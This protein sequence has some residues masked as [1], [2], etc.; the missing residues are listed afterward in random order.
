M[1]HLKRSLMAGIFVLCA[2]YCLAA[3]KG[4]GCDDNHPTLE[5]KDVSCTGLR[6][7]NSSKFYEKPSAYVT[8]LVGWMQARTEV[9]RYMSDPSF[10]HFRH[11]FKLHTHSIAEEKIKIWFHV[12]DRGIDAGAKTAGSLGV[13]EV[14]F[15]KE[16]NKWVSYQEDIVHSGKPSGGV[17]R[18]SLFWCSGPDKI[19]VSSASRV[20]A[21]EAASRESAHAYRNRQ[22]PSLALLLL[23][24]LV[25]QGKCDKPSA[26]G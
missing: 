23:T 25:I 5:I 4:E 14:S 10:L 8:V 21:E 24:L 2:D 26:C 3:R 6:N 13:V 18:F 22:L 12:Y 15:P 20:D 9:V 11:K 17:L 7:G 16:R 19:N 1:A